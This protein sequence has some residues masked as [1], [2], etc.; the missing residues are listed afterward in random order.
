M[1]NKVTNVY[2]Q[3]CRIAVALVLE[4]INQTAFAPLL[5]PPCD[6][7]ESGVITEG[8]TPEVF[9]QPVFPDVAQIW[10]VNGTNVTVSCNAPGINHVI[11]DGKLLFFL[12]ISWN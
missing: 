1:L 11:S 5:L 6:K 4:A 8:S 12:S 3:V 7:L 2:F 10:N 9:G